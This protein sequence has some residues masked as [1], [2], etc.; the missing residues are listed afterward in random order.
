M[1]NHNDLGHQGEQLAVDYLLKQGYSILARNYRFQKAE[2]DIIAQKNSVLII[3]EVKTRNR[4]M[5]KIK[6]CI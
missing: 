4:I 6:I 2:I 5:R 3:L 1:A